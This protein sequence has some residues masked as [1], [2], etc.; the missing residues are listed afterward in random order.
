M[1][2]SIPGS[3]HAAL[4]PGYR[5]R[6]RLSEGQSVEAVHRMVASAMAARGLSP[7]VLAD[8][9]CGR[10]DFHA[11]VGPRCSRYIGVDAVR[12]DGFPS[13][14]EFVS[15]DLNEASDFALPGGPADVVASLETIEHLENPR[16][17]M[18]LLFRLTRPGGW[19]FVTTPNQRST[20]SLA[21]LV[22]KGH[23]SHFQDVHYP[24]H[25]TA[26]LD[27]DLRRIAGEIG[28]ERV[29]IE[30]TGAGRIV[31]SAHH[32]PAWLSRAFPRGLS[33]NLLLAGQRPR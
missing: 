28:L 8:V 7:V 9:G 13:D 19:V 27:V 6:A 1:T 17:F 14:A 12:Y 20:L 23:F 11:V 29:A 32:Y 31:F 5:E 2:P 30:Y 18:R 33:D 15:A 10:G 24:A 21:T 3:A 16:A 22:T 4:F 25:L 26:L